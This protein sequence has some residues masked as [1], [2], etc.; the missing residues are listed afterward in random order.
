[1]RF[2]ETTVVAAGVE[3][4]FDYVTDQTKLTEWNEHVVDAEVLGDGP[5]GVGTVLRQHR[6][7]GNK[8]FDLTFEVVEHDRPT[9]HCVTG[10]VFGV[11]T[12]MRFDFAPHDGGTRITQTAEV[13]GTGLRSLLA[14]LVAKEM[15]KSVLTGL[16]RLRARL[17]SPADG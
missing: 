13:T 16:D 12:L 17:G 15:H 4:S 2:S 1:M 6:Q 5:V 7:R 9:L 10:T 8:E 3:D 14:R 11:D